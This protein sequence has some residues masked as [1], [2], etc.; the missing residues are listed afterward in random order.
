MLS[1]EIDLYRRDVQAAETLRRL[2]S[3]PSQRLRKESEPDLRVWRV[4]RGRFLGR[5]HRD[6]E[7]LDVLMR[8]L[9]GRLHRTLK[10][11]FASHPESNITTECKAAWSFDFFYHINELAWQIETNDVTALYTHEQCTEEDLHAVIMQTLLGLAIAWE[12][13]HPRSHPAKKATFI[14]NVHLPHRML[15][16][17]GTMMLLDNSEDHSWFRDEYESKLGTLPAITLPNLGTSS[18]LSDLPRVIWDYAGHCLSGGSVSSLDK[19]LRPMVEAVGDVYVGQVHGYL[20]ETQA[21]QHTIFFDWF[22]S[23]LT[24]RLIFKEFSNR[25]FTYY[26]RQWP[27]WAYEDFVGSLFRLS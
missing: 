25:D 20:P 19:I 26:T 2:C 17:L 10:W 3:T 8:Y 18:G 23:L 16:Q 6:Q 22:T 12:T 27:V 1:N 5:G 9:D 11:V 15:V 7:L 14:S 21:L 24:L 4:W 13:F